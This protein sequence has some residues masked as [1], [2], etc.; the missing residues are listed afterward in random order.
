MRGVAQGLFLARIGEETE[1]MARM[2][3][4]RECDIVCGGEVRQQGRDL[5]RARQP[6]RAAP[7]G[8]QAGDV[9]AGEVNAAA[10]RRQM[11][12]KLADQRGLAGAVRPNDGVQLAAAD[13]ERHVVGRHDAA[14]AAHQFL[15]AQQGI[16]HD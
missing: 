5:E 8:R 12:G 9:A 15:D 16:S 13:I 2:G 4:R 10:M 6:Q 14:E 3:L 11:A 1:R 7:P